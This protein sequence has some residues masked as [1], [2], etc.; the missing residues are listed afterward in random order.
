MLRKICAFLVSSGSLFLLV[1]V[2]FTGCSGNQNL[3]HSPANNPG[4]GGGGGSGSGG[5]GSTVAAY[6]YVSNSPAGNDQYQVTAYSADANGQLTPVTGS[7]FNDNVAGIAVSGAYLMGDTVAHVSSTGAVSNNYVDAF[8]IGSDGSLTSASQTK[9][10]QFGSGCGS[11]GELLSDRTGQAV[12]QI[13]YDID[14]QTNKGIAS[15]SVDPSTGNLSYLG[16]IVTGR[17]GV[18]GFSFAG[19]DAYAYAS[20]AGCGSLYPFFEFQSSSTGLLG[21]NSAFNGPFPAPPPGPPGSTGE[22]LP[23]LTGADSSNHV[24]VADY[25]CF[26]QGGPSPAQTQLAA[27]TIGADGNLTTTDTYAT[28]PAA[29]LLTTVNGELSI[30]P[31]DKFLAVADFGGLQIYHFNGA[32]PITPFTGLLTTDNI[33]QIAWD[34][35]DHLYAITASEPVP[36]T[37]ALTNAN[38][39][40]VF[41]VT[42]TAVTPAP[43]S[44]Y[45]IAFPQGLAIQSQ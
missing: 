32:S 33:S 2:F 23:D 11:N 27:Y 34:K 13:E 37:S 6:V 20:G 18:Y 41:T 7:P 35:N 15:Y 39:L 1:F 4:G 14:C 36:P 3:V 12:Y 30:S 24:V 10:D 45:T 43:G 38:K 17:S 40:Y 44:P 8:K 26:S 16:D 42:D 29:P 31:S 22:Y 19:N 21:F 28:M 9:M 25:P 5:S